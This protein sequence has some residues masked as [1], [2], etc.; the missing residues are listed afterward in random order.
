MTQ[1]LNWGPAVISCAQ[2]CF[3]FYKVASK[4]GNNLSAD[5]SR[6]NLVKIEGLGDTYSF[7]DDDAAWDTTKHHPHPTPEE[8]ATAIRSFR[9]RSC[10]L[11]LRRAQRAELGGRLPRGRAV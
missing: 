6:D 7:E 3:D 9:F 4:V 8:A 10:R 5:R 2:I 1:G 11:D